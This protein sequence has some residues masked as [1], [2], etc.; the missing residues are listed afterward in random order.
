MP[1]EK[2]ENPTG[3]QEKA[4]RPELRVHILIRLQSFLGFMHLG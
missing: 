3:G 4:G 2:V 1:S